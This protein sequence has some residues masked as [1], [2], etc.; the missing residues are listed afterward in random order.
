M[1][2]APGSTYRLQ[3]HRGFRFRD[4][5]ALI[6]YFQALGAGCL[7]LSPVAAA[8]RGSTHG[9]DVVDPRRLNPELG[10]AAEF[11]ALAADL[12]S[13][14]MGLMLDIVPNH[15]AA[16]RENRW[17]MD[18]LEKGR[19]SRFA[20]WFDIDWRS[21]LPG[22]K[23]KVLLP[24]L[25]DDLES[26]LSR[27]ALRLVVE[28]GRLRLRC[29]GLVLPLD[30]ATWSM[31]PGW[32]A[33][34][35]RGRMAGR[36]AHRALRRK[37]AA[38]WS[39]G[40]APR[41]RLQEALREVNGSAGDPRRSGRLRALLAAQH[42][43][44]EGWRRA[45][46]TINYR[47]FF[48]ISDLVGVRPEE[49]GLFEALHA[50]PL[51]MA[52]RGLATGVRVDHIDGLADPGAYLAALRARL[53]PG[54]YLVVEKILTAGE[55]LPR[56]WPVQ[57]TTG[58]DTLNRLNELFVD[59]RGAAA[60][61]AVYARFTGDRS[62]YEEV[63]Y[64]RKRRIIEEHFPGDARNLA[65]ALA[66]LA[67]V[68]AG[69][70]SADELERAVIE[71][72][73]CL[74]VYRTYLGAEASPADRRVI[75]RAVREALRRVG[76]A[77]R[78]ILALR[79]VLLGTRDGGAERLRFVQRWQQFT[80]PVM[81]KGVEDTALYVWGRLLSLNEVG[82][83]PASRGLAP[84]AFHAFVRNRA[85][86]HPHAMNA[87][88]THDTK[89]GEDVRARLNVLSEIPG[90]WEERLVRWRR[91]NRG[92][93]RR[94]RG[95]EVP[96]PR[97]EIQLYQMLLGAWPLRE[98]RIPAFLRRFT[99]YLVKAAREAKVHTR[100]RR[101]V[102]EHEQALGE[103]VEAILSRPGHPF[104]ADFLR[105]ERRL[106]WHGALNGLAQAALKTML[107]GVP[108]LYQGC[109]LWD[110]RLVD[111]DNRRPVD[112]ARRR[113]ILDDLRRRGGSSQA[114]GPA[115]TLLASWPDGRIKLYLLWRGLRL[116]QANERLFLRGEHLP[117]PARG[118]VS[119]HVV[120]FAR[121]RGSAWVIVAAARGTVRL[122]LTGSP[123]WTGAWRGTWLP[124]PAAAPAGWTEILTGRTVRAD[125]EGPG[126]GL[127][128]SALLG[129]LPVALLIG[130][131]A[132]QPSI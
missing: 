74:P 60:L 110:L 15:M 32:G 17:W 6:P 86:L 65:L 104:R 51:S 36:P 2:A 106:A 102:P 48:N 126:R 58:Y 108:D 109:E 120:A 118:A 57:G 98:D 88:A 124:L 117:L 11:Q 29:G 49:P 67:A 56:C 3:L 95:V 45:P 96:D 69:S 27:G 129:E 87:T 114:G 54:V 14:G 75:G 10:T 38:A 116:R 112:F 123:P 34:A 127:H 50:L 130:G 79:G 111:P 35:L 93:K 70:P 46:E 16:S 90:E 23:D 94:V 13:R 37:I 105:L 113:R 12:R 8:R 100:W 80:G 30:P 91:W 44:L 66:R 68:G 121:R 41:A 83:E 47:R 33:A 115:R 62:R 24:V 125:A 1:P 89:R 64:D 81:A 59:E 26:E 84:A 82:G 39:R 43:R 42:Y 101:P 78:G 99:Q 122:G 40:G 21:P 4:A 61:D 73:A 9:Y 72:T 119:S 22:L 25:Q 5:R 19:R 97:E 85:R 7:Y 132:R 131:S 71:V 53:G 31:V 103:F 77:R 52:A 128:L 107:P 28:D 76:E 55:E 92:L 18:V 63:A 20:R